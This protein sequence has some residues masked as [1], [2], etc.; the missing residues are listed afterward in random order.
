MRGV[1]IA[2]ALAAAAAAPARG[3]AESLADAWQMA[4]AHDLSLAAA[5]ADVAAA[6][7]DERS[8]R[9]AR[10]PSVDANAGYTRLGDSPNL[11]ITTQAGQS[12]QSG[13]VFR[14]NQFTTGTVQIKL[15]LYAGGRIMAGIDAAHQAVT[16]SSEMEH[17]TA[18]TL[19]LEVAEAYVGVLRAR[20]ALQAQVSTVDSLTAHA[21]DV[22]QMVETQSVQRSDLLAA[23]V[24]LANAEEQRLRAANAVQIAQAVYNRRLG[25]PL[26]RSP[27][28][29][30]A[31]PAVG[32]PSGEAIEVLIGHA[33]Q[34]RS[35]VKGYAAQ[36]DA[37]AAQSRAETGKLL[38]QLALTGSYVHFDNQILDRE[39]LSMVGIGVTWNL[40]DG[41]Q[42]RDHAAAL[43]SASHAQQSRLEDLRSQISLEVR[44]DW[45]GVQEA[46]ARV[47][48][49]AEAVA[50]A[51]ENL[52]MSRELYAVGLVTNTQVLD[53]VAARVTA[54]GNRDNAVLDEALSRL[55]LARA[56]GD[57]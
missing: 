5:A 13:P 6:Q 55:R 29:E 56:V 36:V 46:Q 41:G 9:G 37:L 10:W 33:L 24:A 39:N 22:Q 21:A 54:L 14:N 44:V 26:D 20:R 52:R 35:E 23:K 8:A 49:S 45:L 25:Q 51:Q 19:R 1:G 17:A 48:A 31:L 40:F 7:A 38:P 4:I 32:A 16:A 3:C 15:P 50:E 47:K 2:L 27:E 43:K 34:T 28:L 53:A 18:S 30:E 11:D 42:A 57:L 12:L